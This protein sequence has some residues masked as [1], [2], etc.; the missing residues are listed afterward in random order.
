MA[1]FLQLAAEKKTPFLVQLENL[2]W[3]FLFC[4]NLV[5]DGNLLKLGASKNCDM[6]WEMYKEGTTD[7][8]TDVWSRD[9]II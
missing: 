7:K 1:S 9:L 3:P 6:Q 5:E 2:F 8:R 4:D